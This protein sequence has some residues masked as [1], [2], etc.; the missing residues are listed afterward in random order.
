MIMKRRKQFK[1]HRL[2]RRNIRAVSVPI[3]FIAAFYLI[4][5]FAGSAFG[6]RSEI[7]D[8]VF[9]IL[10]EHPISGENGLLS[11]LGTFG[12]YGLFFLVLS[13]T[14]IGFL[15]VPFVFA[16]KGFLTGTLLMTFLQREQGHRYDLALVRFCLPE[17][18]SLSALILLGSLCTNLSFRLLCRFRGAPIQ[19]DSVQHNR[20]LAGVFV[21]FLCA[22]FTDAYVV[23]FLIR[24]VSA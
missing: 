17:L 24:M 7:P 12:I 8:S 2:E 16:G 22:A 14:Y 4:G 18:F 3:L 13:T 5:V 15:L 1:R 6:V 11:D 23:P 9:E 21:L 19:Q 20:V 10:S